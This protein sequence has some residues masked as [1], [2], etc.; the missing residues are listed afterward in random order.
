VR[1]ILVGPPGA[2]KGTQAA[3]IV[4]RYGIPHISTG[5]MLRSAIAAGTE[6]GRRAE[7]YIDRGDLVP[8]EV[9][10]ALVME[11]IGRHDCSVGFL[12]D[13][14][15]RTRQQAEALDEALHGADVKLTAVVLLD[16]PDELI[17]ERITGRRLDPA[18][19]RIYH[20]KFTP[21]PLAVARRVVQRADDTEATCRARLR[22]YHAETE[23][24]V[25]HYD[26]QAL[27]RRVDGTGSPAEVS[28]RVL[29]ALASIA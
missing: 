21:P 4:Q 11:R 16:V 1:L 9:V 29:A 23:A 17:L 27:L 14:F 25:P 7:V 28:H 12:L 20:I 24:I 10:I 3:K 2:G 13:G 8:D 6:V 22:K 26:S 18:T 19:G 5:D 15:P